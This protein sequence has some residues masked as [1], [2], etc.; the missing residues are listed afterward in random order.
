MVNLLEM[1][2]ERQ[3]GL[4]G[5]RRTSKTLML[6]E[7]GYYCKRILDYLFK[8]RLK[9]SREE[10]CQGKKKTLEAFVVICTHDYGSS[11]DK[12]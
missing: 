12:R 1:S 10:I 7:N 3:M 6:I 5:I 9:V 11:E 4:L 8:S 2:S